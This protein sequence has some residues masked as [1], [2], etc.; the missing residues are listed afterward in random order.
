M[1]CTK[2]HTCTHKNHPHIALHIAHVTINQLQRQL[3]AQIKLE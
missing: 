1:K 2:T 3:P